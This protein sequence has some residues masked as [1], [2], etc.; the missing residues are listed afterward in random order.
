MV[1]QLQV[2]I[3]QCGQNLRLQRR[4]PLQRRL[5][6]NKSY[7]L[8]LTLVAQGRLNTPVIGKGRTQEQGALALRGWHT[9]FQHHQAITQESQRGQLA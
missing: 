9:C 1:A 2:T 7:P 3:E 4:F 8:K 6:Q 5:C